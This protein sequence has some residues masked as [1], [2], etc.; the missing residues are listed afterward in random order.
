MRL[1][2]FNGLN[3]Q[4][5]QSP[6]TSGLKERARKAFSHELGPWEQLFIGLHV[7]LQSKE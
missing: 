4:L 1:L 2:L 7:Y 6:Q 5:E 3:G